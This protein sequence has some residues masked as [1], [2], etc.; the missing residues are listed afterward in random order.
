MVGL[1][2]V[3]ARRGGILGG[4]APDCAHLRVQ[5]CRECEVRVA[6]MGKKRSAGD[7]SARRAKTAELACELRRDNLRRA[8]ASSNSSARPSASGAKAAG[9]K[10]SHADPPSNHRASTGIDGLDHIL[11]G[12]FTRDRVYL[13]EGN[14]GSGKTTLA[15]QFLRDGIRRGE[16]VLY[17]ALSE[18]RAE[19]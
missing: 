11:G 16:I 14:P 12:G 19:L 13:V 18:T 9:M 2:D 15:L 1:G 10:R 17:V 5:S 7:A 8:M 6:P 3:A 4:Q